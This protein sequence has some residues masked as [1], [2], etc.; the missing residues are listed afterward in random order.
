MTRSVGQILTKPTL[1]LKNI[2]A[3]NSSQAL[4][5]INKK[6]N[7]VDEDDIKVILCASEQIGLIVPMRTSLF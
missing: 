3:R 4:N 7:R 2:S 1:I 5:H 6:R